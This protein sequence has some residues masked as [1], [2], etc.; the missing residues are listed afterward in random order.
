MRLKWL[1]G[2]PPALIVEFIMSDK[3]FIMS[4]KEFVFVPFTDVDMQ[5]LHARAKRILTYM[6][7]QDPSFIMD[8]A[9]VLAIFGVFNPSNLPMEKDDIQIYFSAYLEWLK[10]KNSLN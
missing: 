2:Q 3:E 8:E 1:V 6:Q 9:V 7:K 4:D 5:N 10:K